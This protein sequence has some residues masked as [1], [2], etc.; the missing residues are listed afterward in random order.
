MFKQFFSGKK[1]VIFD[2]DGTLVDTLDIWDSAFGNVYSDLGFDWKGRN[3]IGGKDIPDVWR[4]YLSYA[5]ENP[6]VSISELTERTKKEFI[7][8]LDN[9]DLQPREGFWTFS[10]KLKDVKEFKLG[11]VTNTDKVVAEKVV[12]KLGVQKVFEVILYGDDVNRK[13]PNPALYN[14]ARKKMQLKKKELLVFE[15]SP[16]GAEAASAANLDLIIVWDWRRFQKNEFPRDVLAY[17]EDFSLFS[18]NL[19]KTY[20][21]ALLD[22]SEP[23]FENE[24]FEDQEKPPK[25]NSS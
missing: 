18:A 13:K 2:L 15:D 1:G 3:F 4:D 20:K 12:E 22:T 10:V 16:A 25:K 21:E 8:E 23:T 17:V 6:K 24:S 7:S 14:V 11:L 19:D 5:G 9:S